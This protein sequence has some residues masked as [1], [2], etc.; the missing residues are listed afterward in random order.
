MLDRFLVL[1]MLCLT[2]FSAICQP[3]GQQMALMWGFTLCTYVN[4]VGHRA[5]QAPAD[6]PQKTR[7]GTPHTHTRTLVHTRSVCTT[8][9][10]MQACTSAASSVCTAQQ[11]ACALRS[12]SAHC[13]P[14]CAR[15]WPVPS[16]EAGSTMPAHHYCDSK[17]AINIS[18]MEGDDDEL[19]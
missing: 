11:A 8:R 7:T 5:L 17:A 13:A 18:K 19:W 12:A 15:A 3:H 6:T 16:A 9:G 4:Y 2:V 10:K 14:C 1:W